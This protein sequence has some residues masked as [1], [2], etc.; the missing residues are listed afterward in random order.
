MCL[1]AAQTPRSRRKYHV[2][3]QQ[4]LLAELGFVL[5]PVIDV[6]SFERLRKYIARRNAGGAILV[7]EPLRELLAREVAPRDRCFELRHHAH[8][9]PREQRDTLGV[10]Q[11]RSALDALTKI[12]TRVV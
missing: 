5:D 7:D 11:Q 4:R 10:G 2:I 1:V 9:E 8:A 12:G 3:E 6:A